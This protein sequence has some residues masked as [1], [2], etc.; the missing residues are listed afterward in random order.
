[1]GK[2]GGSQVF[3]PIDAPWQTAPAPPYAGDL[4]LCDIYG[5]PIGVRKGMS[6]LI[7][8]WILGGSAVAVVYLL[9]KE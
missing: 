1:M 2:L 4:C 7:W 5:Q 8:I 3:G 9:R 6:F